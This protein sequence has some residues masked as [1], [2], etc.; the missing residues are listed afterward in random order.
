MAN[1]DDSSTFRQGI[2]QYTAANLGL[3]SRR[4]DSQRIAKTNHGCGGASGIQKLLRHRRIT[5]EWQLES[6]QPS[7]ATQ[8]PAAKRLST[9]LS[10]RSAKSAKDAKLAKRHGRHHGSS[11]R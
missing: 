3:Y 1:A 5:H 4:D 2:N 8:Y 10:N 11:T 7:I 9:A 6:L